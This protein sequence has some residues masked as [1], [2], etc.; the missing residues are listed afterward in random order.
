MVTQEVQP[1][2]YVLD[3]EGIALEQ[4]MA[5]TALFFYSIL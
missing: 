5:F 1:M 3:R 4:L 2:T